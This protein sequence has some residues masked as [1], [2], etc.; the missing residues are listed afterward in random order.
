MFDLDVSLDRQ[1]TEGVTAR[2]TIVF[3]EPEDPRVLTAASQVLKFANI[4]LV[5]K[6]KEIKALLDYKAVSLDCSRDRFFSQ[7]RVVDPDEDSLRPVLAEGLHKL[8]LGRKWEMPVE[9]ALKK[10]LDPV[11]FGVMLVRLGYADAVLGGV[12]HATKDFLAPCLRLLEREGVVYEMGLFA[13]PDDDDEEVFQR[14]LVMFADVAL[15]PE[16]SPEQL[17][18]IAVGACRTMRDIIPQDVLPVINGAVL[19]YS[20]KGSGEGRTV[21]RVRE[22]DPLIQ[23]RLAEL[24]KLK[25]AYESINIITE[26]QISVAISESAAKTKLKT[27]FESLKGA[28][29]AN[30]LIAPNLDMGN[31]LYHLYSTR[32]PKA[33]SSLIMG[34]M[35]NQALDYSRGS[36]VGQVSRGAK[37]LLLNRLRSFNYGP[38]PKDHYFPRYRVLAVNPGTTVTELAVFNGE[39]A[40]I[41][42][43]LEHPVSEIKGF[44][45]MADQLTYR[46]EKIAAFLKENSVDLSGLHAAV[47]SCG[48]IKPAPA[49]VFEVN[50]EMVE[51]LL[52]RPT[53]EHASN[54]GAPLAAWLA[55]QA[56]KPAYAVDAPTSDELDEISRMTGHKDITNDC[57]WHA[58]SQKAA[59]RLLADQ[60]NK[61]YKELNLII[62]HLGAG[63]SIGAHRAGRCVKVN[64]AL[65]DGPMSPVRTGT[66]P[67]SALLELCYS[68]APR[69]AVEKLMLSRGGLISY[70]KT[71]DLREIETLAEQGE[72]QARLALEAMSEQIAG[73]IAYLIPKFNGEPVDRIILTGGMCRSKSLTDSLAGRLAVLG[74]PLTVYP[75]GREL[76]ALR[77]AANRVLKG[78]EEPVIYKR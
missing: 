51:D 41:R 5:G 32:Y 24:K 7:V 38:T 70:F 14:N 63:I 64:N 69:Q 15:N 21:Q 53:G 71:S 48:L 4:I 6:I 59:G 73:H 20:T 25:P 10:V 37:L 49:A 11:F 54:L 28:G 26:L 29:R 74:I 33:Q 62:A 72:R 47:G 12:A 40:E 2:Q 68:G 30:V 9:E 60:V 39:E 44:A 76:E 50:Q 34:G 55:A 75:G 66:L 16:P 23:E 1:L 42:G 78:L 56:G 43:S 8:S 19:S 3:P 31:M 52:T 58:L 27:D 36:S 13:L 22:A 57:V 18:E 77:D 45:S 61:D 67:G 46:Q 65:Y 35:S 17:A